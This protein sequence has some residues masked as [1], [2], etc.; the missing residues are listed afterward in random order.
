MILVVFSEAID[1]DTVRGD[2]KVSG[3]SVSGNKAE[4]SEAYLL[5][6]NITVTFGTEEEEKTIDANTAVVLI[7]KNFN[8][9]VDVSYNDSFGMADAAPASNKVKSF[10]RKD[11]LKVA[12]TDYTPWSGI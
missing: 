11:T 2:N 8:K 12:V 7:G 1:D 3:F 5:D 10:S 9:Y 6:E 4:L